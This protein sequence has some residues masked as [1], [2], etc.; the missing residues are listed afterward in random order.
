MRWI[1]ATHLERWADTRT[2][3]GDLPLLIR[4]LIVASVKQWPDLYIAAGDSIFKPGWDGVC[5]ST[6]KNRLLPAGVSRWEWGRNSDYKKKFKK[7]FT[8]RT[9]ETPREKQL[10]E[11]FVFV[12]PRRWSGDRESIIKECQ[13]SSHWKGI[14]IYDADDLE[15]WLEHSPAVARWLC[16]ELQIMT[17]QVIGAE[18]FWK[19]Y[20]RHA[21][22]VFTP[23]FVLGGRTGNAERLAGFLTDD[24]DAL[25]LK[26]ASKE[27][28]AAFVLAALL[29]A[30][31]DKEILVYSKCVIV[32]EP[33]V[34][35]QLND[36]QEGLVII[37]MPVNDETITMLGDIANHII[38]IVSNRAK[39]RSRDIIL[40]IPDS[41]YFSQGL[42]AIG[43][44]HPEAY[45]LSKICG[46]SYDVLRRLLSDQAGRV[47]W[48]AGF[49]ENELIPLFFVQKFDDEKKGDHD[50]IT[51]L[52]GND[53]SAYKSKLKNGP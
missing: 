44:P 31:A 12:T 2:A 19:S 3:E 33:S 8:K 16:L 23:E 36:L 22:Y 48:P 35:K 27:E 13:S 21:E 29:S 43:V 28:G 1:T 26:A 14:L 39:V 15:M 38:S 49:D 45:N 6:E 20:T 47:I 52:S 37:Y 30:N 10:N 25:E 11:I 32:S 53:Y 17:E 34:L 50:A 41:G 40:Q 18:E 5:H 46:R 51:A 4:K 24:F 7:D 42:I 9:L